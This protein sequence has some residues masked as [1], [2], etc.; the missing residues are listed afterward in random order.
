MEREEG[1]ERTDREGDEVVAL[2]VDLLQL[3]TVAHCGRHF[4]QLVVPGN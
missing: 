2:H 3:D 1:G 4:S